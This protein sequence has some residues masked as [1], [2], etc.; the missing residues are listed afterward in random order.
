MWFINDASCLLCLEITSKLDSEG[1]NS[2][3][4]VA[5]GN[6]EDGFLQGIKSL[7][8]AVFYTRLW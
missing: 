6:E 5:T 8:M 7:Y 3:A 1:R 4:V 2:A